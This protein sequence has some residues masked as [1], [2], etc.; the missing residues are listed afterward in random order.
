MSSP[1][2]SVLNPEGQKLSQLVVY[3]DPDK[4]ILFA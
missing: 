3:I 2:V 1:R 4:E